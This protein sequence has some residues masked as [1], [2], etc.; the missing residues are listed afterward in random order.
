M[1]F[2]SGVLFL[3]LIALATACTPG[4]AP[5]A[6][7]PA[8]TLAPMTKA[9]FSE[10]LT[11]R[12]FRYSWDTTDTDKCLAPDRWPSNP[13]SSLAA[14]GFALP[15]FSLGAARVY[16]TRVQSHLRTPDFLPLLRAL[17]RASVRA[18]V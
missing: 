14:P 1:S 11:E 18:S 3:P 10:E 16:V 13:F 17:G 7:A 6:A 12:T 4:P 5:T 15:A 9:A 2:R 8:P